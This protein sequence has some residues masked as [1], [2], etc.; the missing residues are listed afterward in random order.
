MKDTNRDTIAMSFG[1]IIL[2]AQSAR[3]SSLSD[4]YLLTWTLAFGKIA[5]AGSGILMLRDVV[6]TLIFFH[7]ERS[8]DID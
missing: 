8:R 5:G 6:Y 7:Y 1:C 3:Q 2:P 4:F